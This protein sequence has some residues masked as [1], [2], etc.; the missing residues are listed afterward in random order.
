MT[1]NLI[2]VVVPVHNREE[3]VIETIESL[4]A[5][6]SDRWELLLVDD[7]SSDDSW[8]TISHYA[9]LYNNIFAHLNDTC[10]KG[11]NSVRNIGMDHATYDWVMFLDSDDLLAPNCIEERLQILKS[12]PGKDF[13]VYGT[14]KFKRVMGDSP[15]HVNV[16]DKPGE[17]HLKRFL[18]LDHPW[19]STGVLWRKSYL[20]KCG[21]WRENLPSW[22]DWE[23]HIRVLTTNPSYTVIETADSFLRFGDHTTIGLASK[24]KAHLLA[25]E[26]LLFEMMK[27]FSQAKETSNVDAIRRVGMTICLQWVLQEDSNKAL[28]LWKEF[29]GKSNYDYNGKT[30]AI[31]F[32]LYRVVH[33]CIRIFPSTFR[34]KT[35]VV[36]RLLIFG[37]SVPPRS[38]TFHKY[39]PS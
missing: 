24:Q 38:R 13:Y 27:Q 29:C 30:T 22:Q 32:W 34:G 39:K 25:H 20:E 10:N 6:T 16:L 26:E 7:Y 12:V 15:L 36:I 5:Q 33:S 18:N 37:N 2:S 8:N 19:L 3:L 14:R 23:L 28:K 35:N 4:L 11:A 31:K 1:K 17:D 9:S 21:K